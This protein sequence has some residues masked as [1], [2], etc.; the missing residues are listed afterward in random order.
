MIAGTEDNMPRMVEDIKT[1]I[2]GGGTQHTQPVVSTALTPSSDE[3]RSICVES[4][5]SCME[6]DISRVEDD[7]VTRNVGGDTPAVVEKSKCDDAVID[8]TGMGM[9]LEVVIH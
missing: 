9:I 6:E 5:I 2:T 8:I 1:V 3:I 7:E 4:S